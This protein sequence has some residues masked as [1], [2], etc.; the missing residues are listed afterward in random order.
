MTITHIIDL[1]VKPRCPYGWMIEE[2]IPGAPNYE[3]D[4]T[5]VALYLDEGQKTGVVKGAELREKLKGQRVF[6]ANLLDSLLSHPE[7]IP[8]D[9]KGKKVCFWGTIYRG[10]DSYLN[11]RCL[12]WFGGRWYSSCRW[13]FIGF[14]DGYPA[15]VSASL[16]AEASA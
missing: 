5:K 13:L 7:L 3:W 16:P 15:L 9:W 4:P 10:S 6:N 12:C 11:V 8:D 1:E 2:H 14:D